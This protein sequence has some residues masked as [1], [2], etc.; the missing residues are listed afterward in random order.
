MARTREMEWWRVEVCP[1]GLEVRPFQAGRHE[2]GARPRSQASVV[3][4]EIRC[5]L[6]REHVSAGMEGERVERA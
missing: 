2:P 4:L 3:G 6:P 1:E 5:S